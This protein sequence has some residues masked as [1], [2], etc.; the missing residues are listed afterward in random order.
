M[1]RATDRIRRSLLVSILYPGVDYAP[2]TPK[3]F[4]GLVWNRAT[5]RGYTFRHENRVVQR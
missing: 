4:G 5:R 2:K 1:N 3:V